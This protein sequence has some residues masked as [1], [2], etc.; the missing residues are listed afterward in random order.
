MALQFKMQKTLVT[1][2]LTLI[3]KS[4][5]LFIFFWRRIDSKQRK[6]KRKIQQVGFWKFSFRKHKRIMVVWRML[7]KLVLIFMNI[8]LY[9]TPLIWYINLFFQIIKIPGEGKSSLINFEKWSKVTQKEKYLKNLILLKPVEQVK[10]SDYSILFSVRA[11]DGEQ[12]FN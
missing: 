3:L 10:C 8:L 9:K 5:L 12:H 6:K 11:N 7:L 1:F 2:S 4:K